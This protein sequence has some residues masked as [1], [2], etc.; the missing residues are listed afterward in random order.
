MSFRFSW[1]LSQQHP[2]VFLDA[3][4]VV[5]LGLYL[6]HR[7]VG[8]GFGFDADVQVLHALR[9]LTAADARSRQAANLFGGL[10][11]HAAD[12]F[13]LQIGVAGQ[14]AQQS[15]YL[16]AFLP[17]GV[18]HVHALHVLDDVAA[19]KSDHFFRHCPQHLPGLGGGEGDG[20]GFGAAHGGNK[21]FVQDLQI[22]FILTGYRGDGLLSTAG[23]V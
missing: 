19:A 12:D 7:G 14:R 6:H 20:D 5:V 4:D 1:L 2:A 11:R 9:Q 18:G 3:G 15:G 23:C 10:G 16:D 22:I 21:L 13:Q 17:A 8:P